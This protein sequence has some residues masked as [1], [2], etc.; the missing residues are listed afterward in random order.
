[1]GVSAENCSETIRQYDLQGW[2]RTATDVDTDSA[3]WLRD[4]VAALGIE[5][6]EVGF[7]FRRVDPGPTSVEVNGRS[8]RAVALPDSVLPARGTV[9][10]GCAAAPGTPG[11]IGVLR[12]D[13][14]RNEQDLIAARSMDHRALVVAVEGDEGGV[15]LLN[16][17]R[18]ANP[19]GPPVLQVPQDAWRQ[20]EEARSQGDTI[21]IE[22]G[23]GR[24][25]TRAINIVATVKG[26]EPGVA[27]LA[28]LTPRSGWWHCAGERGGGIALWLELIRHLRLEQPRRDV[29]FLATTAHELGYLGIRRLLEREA[30][31]ATRPLVWVHLGANIGAAGAGLV[32]RS[33]DEA[34]LQ[35]ARDTATVVPALEAR[36]Q[37][38]APAV[39]EASVLAEFGGTWL[40]LIGAGYPLFHS[41]ND[42]WPGSL[43][44][45]AMVAAGDLALQFLR[46]LDE[47]S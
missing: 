2:H 32:V 21:R 39:G 6:E 47:H 25:A 27:P 20:L 35:R 43:D 31:L 13:Q 40:S 42:R 29:L 37:A 4:R 45:D 22:C 19:Y 1:M 23:A 14:H 15:T 9:I 33:C 7:D 28:V 44:R 18:F 30:P 36:F 5:A 16:A 34:L 10:E 8:F 38:S 3:H 17:W 26:R 41:T 46:S 24:V 12:I 11:T